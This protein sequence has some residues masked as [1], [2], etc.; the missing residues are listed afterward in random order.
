MEAAC[1]NTVSMLFFSIYNTAVRERASARLP[2]MIFREDNGTMKQA[3]TGTQKFPIASDR[4]ELLSHGS[5]EFP[6]A[7]YL[8]VYQNS[9]YPWH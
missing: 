4:K 8:D 1:S 5:A 6:G 7:V 2:E 9:S 3:N